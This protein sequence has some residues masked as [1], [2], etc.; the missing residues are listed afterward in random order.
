[1][2]ILQVTNYFKPSWDAGGPPRVA[3]EISKKL[4]ENGHDITVYTTDGFKSRLDVETKKPVIVDGIR[5]YYFRNLSIFLSRSMN[6]PIPYYLPLVATN[7]VKNFEVIHI[8]D[9]RSLLAVVIHYYSKKYK[10]PYILQ[11]H[12][13]VL[14]FFAKQRLKRLFDKAWGNKILKDATKVIA[15]TKTEAEQYK[16]MGVDEDKI[17]IVPNGI[18]LA[19][20]EKLPDKGIFRNKYGIKS[21]EK[22]VL[23]LARIHK[24]KGVDLLVEAFSDLASKMEGVTLIIAGPNDGFLSTLKAQIEDLKIGDRILFTGPLY[25]MNKLEAYVDADVYVLPSVYETFPVTVLEACVCGT[26]VIV[27]DRCGIAEIVDGKV[28]IVVGYDEKELRDAIFKVL[29]DGEL[30]RKFGEEGKKIVRENYGWN[31]IIKKIEQIYH[32]IKTYN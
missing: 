7:E 26:T 10:I 17:E 8:H 21:D 9:Y 22:I 2:K 12:G 6:L 30:R 19:E 32:E 31:L 20:Y 11:A 4:I 29:L 3:Y 5:T 16:K 23:F 28:G 1:M 24:I 25:G 13:A 18:D 14:P 27:T 15:L